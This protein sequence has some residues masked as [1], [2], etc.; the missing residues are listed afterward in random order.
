MKR[1]TVLILALVLIL[2][3]FAACAGNEDTA[4]VTSSFPDSRPVTEP[5]AITDAVTDLADELDDATLKALY[6]GGEFVVAGWNGFNFGCVLDYDEPE[7]GNILQ[8][9]AY[10]RNEEIRQRFG[11]EVSALED[12]WNWNATSEGI[13]KIIELCSL[14]DNVSI[15]MILYFRNVKLDKERDA[16]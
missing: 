16:Q 1:F 5:A 4:G 12:L 7:A 11:V 10:A 9:A 14:A 2:S 6:D 3:A 13:M 15:D 8:E